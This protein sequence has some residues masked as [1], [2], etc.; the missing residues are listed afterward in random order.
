MYTYTCYWECTQRYSRKTLCVCMYVCM[1]VDEAW[2]CSNYIPTGLVP[3]A[4]CHRRSQGGH[5]CPTFWPP[6]RNDDIFKPMFIIIHLGQFDGQHCTAVLISIKKRCS[7]LDT[8]SDANCIWEDAN[9][10]WECVQNTTPFFFST[11]CTHLIGQP[12]WMLHFKR[13]GTSPTEDWWLQSTPRPEDC[14]QP[15][16]THACV[17]SGN[18]YA[19]MHVCMHM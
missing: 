4:P 12:G 15:I 17:G 7:A 14:L 1:H 10:I 3:M 8:F 16:S 2:I 5:G 13:A 6:Q 18:S 9:C 19:C 11:W